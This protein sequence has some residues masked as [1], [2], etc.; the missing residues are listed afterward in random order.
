MKL[1]NKLAIS[2]LLLGAS[3]VTAS[4]QIFTPGDIV[5]SV[6]GDVGTQTNDY[7]DGQV[8]PI[9]LE[10]F[11][12]TI[13]PLVDTAPVLTTTLPTTGSGSNVGIV[14]EY[15]SSSEGTLQLSGD[16]QYLT[17]GGYDAVAAA[18]GIQAATNSANGTSFA[19]GTPYGGT[20][21]ALGQSADTD[22]PRVAGLIDSNG[23]VD[24]S[25]VFNDIYNTNNPRSVYSP[26]G[27]SLYL[28]GQGAGA[29]DEGGLYLSS[30]GTNTTTGV[31]APTPIYNV[32]S[33][34]TVSESNINAAN[35]TVS[36]TANL[37]YSA[38]Q[39]SKSK[40]TQTGIFEYAGTPTGSEGASTGTMITPA[41]N[42]LTGNALISYS[43]QGYFFA[44]ATTLY[45]A[46]TGDPK[47]GKT[48]DGGIQKWSYSAATGKWVLDYT[49]RS[50]NLLSTTS[51]TTAA[52]GETGYEAIAG[53][54]V[55]GV[56][57][58]YAVS[59]TAGDA[60]PN[61]LYGVAD[62]LSDTTAAQAS[63]ETVVELATSD[64]DN[65]TGPDNDFKGVSFAPQAVATPEPSSWILAGVGVLAGALFGRWRRA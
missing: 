25:S 38:D 61:G 17:I 63:S 53:Q 19:P 47:A 1:E 11:T 20:T 7:L 56:V 37:Y 59:Y 9:S 22:A 23:N 46:D 50:A 3:V 26:D 55:N 58:L 64:A 4:A 48:G 28:S 43:P 42:G 12:S 41:N 16:G 31:P 51:A 5:V 54:V 39:N 32:V 30:K 44:N 49:L 21:V 2:A 14:G 40:G 6:Y 57:D 8:T 36:S 45:V 60:D 62:T 52:H 34:R 35:G 65:G 13:A 33:T 15:G 24:T 18:K 10:E 29:T 27:K